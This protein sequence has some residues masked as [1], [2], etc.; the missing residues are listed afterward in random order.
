MS[1]SVRILRTLVLQVVRRLNKEEL[2][3]VL[4]RHHKNHTCNANHTVVSIVFWDGVPSKRANTLYDVLTSTLPKH[5]IPT[6]RRC[7]TNERCVRVCV[8]MRAHM[9]C[10]CACMYV[11][12]CL[13]VC[14]CVHACEHVYVYMCMHAW[15]C[16]YMNF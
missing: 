2:F 8:C 15:V 11:N 7:S 10:V 5:G 13:C 4:F 6:S 16:S 12:A 3:L 14:L 1:F 9:A